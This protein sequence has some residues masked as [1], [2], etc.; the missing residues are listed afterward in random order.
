MK[1]GTNLLF[2][3][4]LGYVESMKLAAKAGFG[5]VDFDL[6]GNY[7]P[8]PKDE[9]RFFTGLKR[10]TEK[11]GMKISQTHAPY[12]KK[13]CEGYSDFTD[14]RFIESIKT[15][16]RRAKIL[17]AEYTVLH[18]NTPYPENYENVPYD[19]D[20]FKADNFKVCADVLNS[21]KPTLKEYGI[22]ALLEDVVAYDFVNRMHKA[23]PCCTSEECNAYI[24]L[25][26][27]EYFGVCL[28]VGHLN[29]V[30]GE[31]ISEYVSKLGKRIR[32]LHLHDN[33]GMLNDWFGELDRHLP[34]FF[35]CV[36]W[37][38]L[39]ESLKSVGY[40]GVYSFECNSYGRKEY[41]AEFYGYLSRAGK[42][43]FYGDNK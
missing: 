18:L 23:G 22:V 38:E 35:G 9:E 19:Y 40:D 21:L 24:D 26:G 12:V 34:P 29:T 43:I 20:I 39:S 8:E 16:V 2:E 33:F 11:E 10:A 42:D 4:E 17:G 3:K 7:N 30:K 14:G 37:R 15:A 25:L 31:S 13:I 6:T 5:Y 1:L 32:A 36:K 28:D 41:A 27:E